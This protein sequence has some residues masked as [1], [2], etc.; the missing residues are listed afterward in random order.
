MSHYAPGITRLGRSIVLDIN[1]IALIFWRGRSAY[2]EVSI[3]MPSYRTSMLQDLRA[4][5]AHE[6]WNDPKDS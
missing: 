1:Y 6:E 5:Q 4:I 3:Y 2:Q